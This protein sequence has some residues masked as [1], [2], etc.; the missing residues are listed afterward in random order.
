METMIK[1][2]NVN[3]TKH[4]CIQLALQRELIK[5]KELDN[6][7]WA[8][9]L[10]TQTRAFKIEKPPGW[11]EQVWPKI[12]RA[13]N[14]ALAKDESEVIIN[15]SRVWI[16]IGDDISISV[17][18]TDVKEHKDHVFGPFHPGCLTDHIR[19]PIDWWNDKIDEV[20]SQ[21]TTFAHI[22]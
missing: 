4:G 9:W 12:V 6:K 22:K 17:Y 7:E 1:G 2:R 10:R 16:R 13:V 20:T 5:P 21:V 3:R 8:A 11:W 15:E 19:V 14:I 18:S